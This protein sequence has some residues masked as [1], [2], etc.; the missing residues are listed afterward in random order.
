VRRPVPAPAPGP[1]PGPGRIVRWALYGF[2]FS[3]AFD[4][5]DQLA[6][7]VTTMTGALFLL[8]T[9]L[10]PRLCYGRRPAALWWFAAY[11]YIYWLAYALGHSASSAAVT[12]SFLFY[13]QGILIFWACFN[14]MR[15]DTVIRNVVLTLAVAS[16]ILALMTVLGLGKIRETHSG[17]AVVFG[18]NPN[19]AARTLSVGLLALIGLTYG[20]ARSALRPRVIAWPLAA[21]IG[22]A[23]ILGGSRGGL[24]ALAVG[25]WTFSLTGNTLGTRVRN[26]IVAMVAIGLC[27]W[28]ALQVPLMKRRIQQAEGGNLAERQH[29]FPAAWQMFKDRPVIGWGPGNQYVLARRLRL[30]PQ[31]HNTRD[32]H[33]L[34]LEVLTATG[35]LGAIPF[36]MGLWLA[37]WAAWKA[38]RGPEGILP[39]AQMAALL[40]ANLSG[41]YIVLKLQWL[42]LAYA[43]A[44]ATFLAP[45]R[46]LAPAPRARRRR[47]LW[48]AA[49]SRLV[50]TPQHGR[51]MEARERSPGT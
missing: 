16:A 44:S 45:R 11:L 41:N 51:S 32:T 20:R 4:A 46:Q 39:T 48:A 10:Q 36:L 19:L 31:E 12:K 24:L 21:L 47:S 23:M 38:R 27:S 6:L 43:L 35:V 1:G 37:C 28:G 29:I 13:L 18:Q 42:M 8:A 49:D 15:H 9:V 5:P 34:F 17:R 7:E 33:N 26:T 14:L 22:L 50:A 40:I 3:L 2:V 30:S 25:L